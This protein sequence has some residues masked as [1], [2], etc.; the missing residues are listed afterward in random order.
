MKTNESLM[1]DAL[2]T[3]VMLDDKFVV[4]LTKGRNSLHFEAVGA[5]L[6]HGRKDRCDNSVDGVS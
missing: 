1:L 6:Q 3:H 4:K 5:T 2:Q